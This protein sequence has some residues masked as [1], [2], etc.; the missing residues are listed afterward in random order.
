M[1]VI[2]AF[3]VSI[4]MSVCQF[5]LRNSS[6]LLPDLSTLQT[7]QSFSCIVLMKM[8]VQDAGFYKGFPERISGVSEGIYMFISL[9]LIIRDTKNRSRC[10]ATSVNNSWSLKKF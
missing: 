2:F 5:Q 8:R 7:I 4:F 3:T 6:T 10:F 9:N 1:Y